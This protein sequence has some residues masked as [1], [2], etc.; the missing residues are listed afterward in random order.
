MGK[1]STPA[2]SSPKVG[3]SGGSGKKQTSLM[4][5]FKPA[6]AKSKSKSQPLPLSS[7]PLK[8]KSTS[9]PFISSDKENEEDEEIMNHKDNTL[10]TSQPPADQFEK[11]KANATAPSPHPTKQVEPKKNH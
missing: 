3:S 4:D 2:K 10:S 8:S 9:K 5:F 7:S 6:S 11:P 1:L